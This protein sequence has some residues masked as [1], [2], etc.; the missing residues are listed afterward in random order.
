MTISAY[1]EG[2]E[3]NS[4]RFWE[5]NAP[6]GVTAVA[7]AAR[8]GDYGLRYNMT[9]SNATLDYQFAPAPTG[10]W[11]ARYYVRF[12]TALPSADIRFMS[13]SNATATDFYAFE[14]RN[15]DDK[16]VIKS[17]VGGVL[18]ETSVGA[19]VVADTWYR[20]DTLGIG[21]AA[22]V[23]E[24]LQW[25]MAAE[26]LPGVAYAT[27]G[28]NTNYATPLF[29]R[30]GTGANQ[31][32]DLHLDDMLVVWSDSSGDLA[33]IQ[34]AFPLGDGYT[35]RL[36]P[37]GVGTHVN[38][39]SF[40]TSAGAIADSWQLIDTIP[41]TT[42]TDYVEQTTIGANDYLEYTVENLASDGTENVIDVVTLKFT[43]RSSSLNANNAGIHVING[44]TDATAYDGSWI[45]NSSPWTPGRETV[46][47]SGADEWAPGAWTREQVN[48]LLIRWGY[49]DDVDGIPRLPGA[50][51]EVALRTVAPE[52][53]EDPGEGGEPTGEVPRAGGGG[54][55]VTRP[56]KPD[57]VWAI[58]HKHVAMDWQN[59]TM[60]AP[61]GFDRMSGLVPIKAMPDGAGQGSKVIARR[62][63]GDVLWMGSLIAPPKVVDGLAVI[64][65]HG[66]VDTIRRRS[67]RLPYQLRGGQVWSDREGD[68]FNY[69][70]SEK[71]ELFSKGNALGWKVVDDVSFVS[72]RQAGYAIF[73]QD[74]PLRR[75]AFTINKTADMANF[76]LVLMVGDDLG[77]LTD[78]TQWTLGASNPTGTTKDYTLNQPADTLSII[79]RSNTT[80]T[81]ADN[82]RFWLSE[83][84]ING[85]KVDDH[86]T[87]SDIIADLAYRC[88]YDPQRI[89][90]SPI[91]AVPLDWS[92]AWDALADYLAMLD[93]WTWTVEED[94]ATARGLRGDYFGGMRYAEWGRDGEGEW[95]GKVGRGLD[96]SV[97]MLPLYN[98]VTSYFES[99]PGLIQSFT[100]SADDM[101]DEEYDDPLERQ[102]VVAEYPQAV[103]LLNPQADRKLAQSVNQTLLRRLAKQRVQG[104][105]SVSKITNGDPFSIRA[106]DTLH[107]RDFIP[108]LPPQRIVGVTYHP[109]GTATVQLGHDYGIDRL[110]VLRRR[111]PSPSRWAEPP[112]TP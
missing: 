86:T 53:D 55:R 101:T 44:A 87:T 34:D 43:R 1:T 62:P 5:N 20:I 67:K 58:D 92:G 103:S 30:I 107:M 61:G 42:N 74:W 13:F 4:P 36:L 112:P 95:I 14:F 12:P 100:T 41:A 98:R 47:I 78:E 54:A 77:T 111:V 97:T 71:Y 60:T 50:Y 40:G 68:P 3:H 85:R 52:D 46:N 82:A 66:P 25:E 104:S 39:G 33:A 16:I 102:G 65:A 11:C 15:S 28:P 69:S 38:S 45:D 80:H 91:V 6:A 83:L 23:T 59:A 37:N 31:T 32:C 26:G 96:E 2:W 51:F 63:T 24:Q 79:V 17:V 22:G 19:G 110:Q 8:S 18:Q 109:E 7:G 108:K 73:L 29:W 64:D 21:S 49:A 99:P 10:A 84:R 27:L 94:R 76:D 88:D 35:K 81:P 106:G 93:D 89:E 105:V 57:L 9:A 48:G 90:S 56:R 70:N 72:G 75:I